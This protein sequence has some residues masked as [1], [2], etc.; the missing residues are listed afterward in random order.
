MA[1]T[2]A[3]YAVPQAF[4]GGRA[5]NTTALHR[6]ALQGRHKLL[7]F[8]SSLMFGEATAAVNGP[9]VEPLKSE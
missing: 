7:R 2:N 3:F 4:G 5:G 6:T 1:W 9:A 8:S